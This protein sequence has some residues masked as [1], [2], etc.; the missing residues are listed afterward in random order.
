MARTSILLTVLMISGIAVGAEEAPEAQ[1]KPAPAPTVAVK[2]MPKAPP[3]LEGLRWGV[4]VG[5]AFPTTKTFKYFS[6]HSTGFVIGGQ[7]TW[8]WQVDKRWRARLD[9]TAFPKAT[10]SSLAGLKAQEGNT[11][12]GLTG[13]IDYMYFWSGK[14][15]DFYTV[16]GVSL[17]HWSQDASTTGS[18]TDTSLGLAAGAGWQFNKAFGLEAR[19][20]W[21]RWETNI[22]PRTIHNAGTLN[23]EA[24]YRF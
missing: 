20:T 16:V 23:L 4:Q 2:P 3:K 12:T 17:A 21:S 5:V 7:A 6:D 1:A 14:P 22:E 18:K 9:Y 24:S 15:E 11:I 8:D 13:G 19:A 10:V